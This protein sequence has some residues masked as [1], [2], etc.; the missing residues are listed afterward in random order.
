[1]SINHREFYLSRQLLFYFCL[2]ALPLN[3]SLEISAQTANSLK[4]DWYCDERLE[5]D[6]RVGTV[7]EITPYKGKSNPPVMAKFTYE[8]N[9]YKA[10]NA[11]KFQ[12]TDFYLGEQ[13]SEVGIFYNVRLTKGKAFNFEVGQK[14]VF[15]IGSVY[16]QPQMATSQK[17]GFIKPQGYFKTFEQAKADI[18][19]LASVKD[20]DEL[21]EIL[22][23]DEPDILSAKNISVKATS[24]IKPFSKELKKLKIKNNV[25]V[26]VVVDESGRVIKAKAFCAKNTILARL[27]EQAAML[28]RFTPGVIDGKPVKVKGVITYSFTP[29]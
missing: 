16:A 9:K 1:M 27:S 14:Y 25:K 10:V 28:S 7:L 19:F 3:F 22:N 6:L 21:Q 8:S 17:H 4:P 20:L 5:L 2:F 13:Q 15:E 12:M 23:T 24:L 26:F 11:I 18:D 29:Y